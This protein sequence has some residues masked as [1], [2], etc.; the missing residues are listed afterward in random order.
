MG[1]IRL[2]DWF[3]GREVGGPLRCCLFYV[4]IG[5]LRIYYIHMQQHGIYVYVVVCK[6]LKL[7][8]PDS[9]PLTSHTAASPVGK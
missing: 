9:G 8:V 6:C 7:D 3:Y 1:D 2:D 4:S 5:M